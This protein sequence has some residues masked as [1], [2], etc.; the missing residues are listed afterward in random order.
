VLEEVVLFYG[1]ISLS[2]QVS[3]GEILQEG[4]SYG[5]FWNPGK[6][7]QFCRSEGFAEKGMR[8]GGCLCNG[9]FHDL[10]SETM[11]MF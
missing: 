4:G 5:I 10:C 2:V 7:V 11:L 8:L 1:G 6:A 9:F 3:G